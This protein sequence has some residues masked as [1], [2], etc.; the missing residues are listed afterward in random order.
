MNL[1]G[2][3]HDTLIKVS[4]IIKSCNFP[5]PGYLT[6]LMC[7][8]E[9]CF[10]FAWP[11]ESALPHVIK[12][13]AE[14]MVITNHIFSKQ[15]GGK[16]NCRYLVSTVFLPTCASYIN[17]T[18]NSVQCVLPSWGGIHMHIW[19]GY[20]IGK[21]SNIDTPLIDLASFNTSFQKCSKY[22]NGLVVFNK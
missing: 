14:C 13:M 22:S 9:S 10:Q 17:T 5:S 18:V 3:Q 11:G 8:K 15:L 2:M 12:K 7:R 1:M 16:I 21:L 20:V 4:S 6:L 19:D